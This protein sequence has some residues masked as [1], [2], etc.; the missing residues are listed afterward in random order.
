MCA[1]RREA[2]RVR[3]DPDARQV[4]PVSVPAGADGRIVGDEPVRVLEA[5]VLESLELR[6]GHGKE[7]LG[8]Q[9]AGERGSARPVL[10][11]DR[12]VDAHRV[13]QEREEEDH[14]RV[15]PVERLREPE[16]V[17]ADSAP[18]QL[19]MDVRADAGA[20][21]AHLVE[22]GLERQGSSGH[23]GDSRSRDHQV[24]LVPA[25]PGA[26]V[27]ACVCAAGSVGFLHGDRDRF[28]PVTKD[29]VGPA[30][31]TECGFA[32]V[33]LDGARY[34]LVESYG[35]ADRKIPGKVSQSLHL[36]RERA[37][38]L[39]RLLEQHFPGI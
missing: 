14:D 22:E 30:R 28:F 7:A 11:V 10:G 21:R 8:V 29:R 34:L 38:E 17:R 18:V 6:R 2:G 15:G 12:V 24:R 35:A 23:F 4:E 39:K 13:V 5:G 27:P 36:N 20:T 19:A 3:L 32:V 33:E 1:R 37:A 31:T 25:W 26:A 9:L 16:P